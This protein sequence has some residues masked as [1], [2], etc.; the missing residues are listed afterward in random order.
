MT[1]SP[2]FRWHYLLISAACADVP[3]P[4][5][6]LEEEDFEKSWNPRSHTDRGDGITTAPWLKNWY[7]PIHTHIYMYIIY[8]Y[9][10]I[11]M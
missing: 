6:V 5:D 7:L 3:P 11:H 8:V 4:P 10:Y 2:R 1:S 9:I